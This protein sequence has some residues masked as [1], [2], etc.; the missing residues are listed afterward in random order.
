MGLDSGIDSN[1]VLEEVGLG[2]TSIEEVTGRVSD[3]LEV[4]SEFPK[5][6]VLDGK[7]GIT[8]SLVL[9]TMSLEITGRLI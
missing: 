2:S 3:E 4:S 5:E 7:G 9:S 1:V 8:S 6:M